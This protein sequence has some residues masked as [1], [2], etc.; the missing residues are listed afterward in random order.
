M[1]YW[2]EPS[3]LKFRKACHAVEL[4][5]VFD[6]LNETIYTG[7]RGDEQLARTVQN[8]WANFA[9]FGNPSTDSVEWEEYSTDKKE[10]MVLCKDCH[11]EERIKDNQRVLLEN[12]LNR[13]INPLYTTISYNVP[14]VWKS[15]IKILL[16]L[17]IIVAIIF[18]I[19]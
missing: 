16:I 11:M 13:F 10:T 14:F 7:E 9:R 5:Y 3:K 6:N 2:T 1:Y 4:A 12:L 15:L 19:F 8:M 18:L 17:A